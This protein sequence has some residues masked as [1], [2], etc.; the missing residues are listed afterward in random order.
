VHISDGL[1]LVFLCVCMDM[2][3]VGHQIYGHT[4][5]IYMILVNPKHALKRGEEKDVKVSLGDDS[6]ASMVTDTCMYLGDKFECSV[7]PSLSW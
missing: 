4:W 2:H 6:T 1:P 5:C 7:C 3:R